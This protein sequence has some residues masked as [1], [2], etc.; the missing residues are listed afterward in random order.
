VSR[1]SSSVGRLEPNY[2]VVVIGSGYGGAIAAS[3]MARAG[4]RVCLLERG[5]EFSLGD[6]PS[7]A[8]RGFR[9]I[10]YNTETGRRG[11]SLGLFEMH[12]NND[13]NAIVGCGLGGTSL[14]NAGVALKPDSRVWK[15]SRWPIAIRNDLRSMAAGYSRA[16]KMLRPRKLPTDFGALCKLSA[17]MPPRMHLTGVKNFIGHQLT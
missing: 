14:I 2:D 4:L 17:L 10:Q 5:R 9:E 1:L 12:V 15:D 16:R 7:T 13:V 6:F 11:R 8:F 3:R